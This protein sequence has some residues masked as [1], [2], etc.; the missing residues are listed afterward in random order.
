[1]A[2]HPQAVTEIILRGE[3]GRG[4]DRYRRGMVELGVTV[5]DEH[6]TQPDAEPGLVPDG[7]VQ[8]SARSLF[9]GAGRFA[10]DGLGPTLAFYAGYKVAGLTTGIVLATVVAL[11]AWRYE[12][13]RD[14]SGMLAWLTLLVVVI[15]AGAG[16]IADDARAFLAPQVLTTVAW[17]VAFVGS[18]AIGRPL[19]GLFAGEFYPFPDEV[20]ASVT[21]RRIFGVVSIVWGVTNLARAALRLWT[22]KDGD[23]DSFIVVNLLTGFPIVAAMLGWSVWWS[24]RAFRRSEEWGWA[25]A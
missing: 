8:V 2:I 7:S 19:A 13:S 11:A 24:Q 22:L 6:T 1:L 18:V 15:Q 20:R 16:L 4:L 17:G 12:R 5:A 14:R 21:F 10:R 9:R 3:D 23:I 25:M